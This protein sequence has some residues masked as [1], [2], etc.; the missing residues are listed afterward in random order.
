M[1]K[2]PA[3][4]LAKKMLAEEENIVEILAYKINV[5]LV[6]VTSSMIDDMMSAI[7]E[8]EIP[9]FH[10]TTQERDEPNPTDP[11]YVKALSEYEKARGAAAMDGMVMFGI[12]LIDGMPTDMHWLD[13]LKMMEK[14]K[15]LSLADY[16]LDDPVDL[17]YLF[18]RYVI[19]T[20]DLISAIGELSGVTSNELKKQERSF[21][22]IPKR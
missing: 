8:P 2:T 13:K 4:D 3:V 11:T 19:A 9:I 1:A 18:K 10:N 5:R 17:E 7:P 6:P 12:E 20:N 15:K 21:R 16:D 14:R 22:R